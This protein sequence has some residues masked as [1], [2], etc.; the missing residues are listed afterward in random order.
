MEGTMKK[1]DFIVIII[2]LIISGIAYLGI[3]LAKTDTAHDKRVEIKSNGSVIKSFVLNEFTDEVFVYEDNGHTNVVTAQK[4]L[5]SITE[6]NCDDQ[7]CVKT[8]EISKV[9]EIIVCLP[10]R[11]TVEIISDVINSDIDG[12]SE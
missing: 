1:N 4:G 11:F 12:F 9:G 7:I 2:I 8:G 6:A 5:V 3:N 10:H